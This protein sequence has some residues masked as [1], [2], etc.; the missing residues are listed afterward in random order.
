MILNVM[1]GLV[2]GLFATSLFWGLHYLGE[3]RSTLGSQALWA[4]VIF[5]ALTLV[6]TLWR[7]RSRELDIPFPK[8]LAAGLV[9]TLIAAM[10]S[11]L[12]TWIFMTWIDPGFLDWVKEQSLA[13]LAELPLDEE[14]RRTQ[15]EAV[16]AS[17]PSSFIV[18]GMIAVLIRGFLLTLPI[19]ALIR[20]RRVRSL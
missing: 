14:Q 19:A 17:T 16:Q 6:V 7:Q 5:H 18:Q 9:V 1:A 15:L 8:L 13:Q 3:L 2:V 12:G 20:L 11:G 10:V 4:A